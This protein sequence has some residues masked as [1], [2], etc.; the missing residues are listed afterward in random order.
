MYG[1]NG[2]ASGQ[3]APARGLTQRVIIAA[4]HAGHRVGDAGSWMS[5]PQ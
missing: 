2:S 3:A 1:T 5:V 4:E